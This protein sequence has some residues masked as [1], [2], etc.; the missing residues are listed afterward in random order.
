[1]SLGGRRDMQAVS[2]F[3]DTVGKDRLG[4]VR[5]LRY[6]GC[7]PR[8]ISRG[9]PDGKI[10]SPLPILSSIDIFMLVATAGQPGRFGIHSRPKSRSFPPACCSAFDDE[11]TTG[12]GA[13]HPKH[14]DPPGGGGCR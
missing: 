9:L 10:I 8:T 2:M 3:E 5:G 1:V 14:G 11:E 12:L 13:E 6:Q 7:E 4:I